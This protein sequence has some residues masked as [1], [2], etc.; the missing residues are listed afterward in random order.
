[1]TYMRLYNVGW[2]VAYSRET[3]RTLAKF[4]KVV[5]VRTCAE[6]TA[7]R[8]EQPLTYFLEGRGVVAVSEFNNV[9]LD[10]VEGDA[11]VLKYNYANGLRSTP[12]VAIEPVTPLGG[13]PPFIRITGPPRT[14]RL[15]LGRN[16]GP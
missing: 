13:M 10:E 1:M 15:Y 7:Y 4:S 2:I 3:K 14:L 5:E 8:V 16:Q 12:A 6:L 9:V 11:I